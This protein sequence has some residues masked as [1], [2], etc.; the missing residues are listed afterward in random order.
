MNGFRAHS[1]GHRA[2]PIAITVAIVAFA[3]VAIGWVMRL[4]GGGPGF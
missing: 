3:A 4:S 2:A 1:A